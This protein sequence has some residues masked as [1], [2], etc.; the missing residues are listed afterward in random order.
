MAGMQEDE[1]EIPKPTVYSGFVNIKTPLKNI[2][3]KRTLKK[4]KATT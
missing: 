3:K 4:R 1:D 2:E